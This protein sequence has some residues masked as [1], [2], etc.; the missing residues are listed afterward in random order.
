M[1]LRVPIR[2]RSTWITCDFPRLWSAL[3]V[4]PQ[5]TL[6]WWLPSES[7]INTSVDRSYLLRSKSKWVQRRLEYGAE[8]ENGY[9]LPHLTASLVH[10]LCLSERVFFYQT[11]FG[12][13]CICHWE[14]LISSDSAR[15]RKGQ[16]WQTGLCGVWKLVLCDSLFTALKG[17][18]K[19][20]GS[21]C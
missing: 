9:S 6:I 14:K 20:S 10:L 11:D 18:E 3:P 19:P 16:P 13:W 1:L 5:T 12:L 15:E 2:W 17:L 7:P 8:D 4:S 21:E